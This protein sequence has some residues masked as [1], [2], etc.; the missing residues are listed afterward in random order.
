MNKPGGIDKPIT[1]VLKEQSSNEIQCN[2]FTYFVHRSFPRVD[3]ST[4]SFEQPVY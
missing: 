4:S 1:F 3:F 2:C